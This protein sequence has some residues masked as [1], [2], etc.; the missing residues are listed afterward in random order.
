MPNTPSI[1]GLHLTYRLWIAEL[2]HDINLLRIFDDYLLEAKNKSV[3]ARI[4]EKIDAFKKSFSELR[5]E[6]D[7]LR[8]SM[9]LIKMKLASEAR[10]Q[11]LLPNPAQDPEEHNVIKKKYD[12]FLL[13]FEKLNNAVRE[14]IDESLQ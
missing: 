4:S 14:F 10:Q 7:E 1:M 5:T 8:H 9:H 13:S 12:A 11:D 3:E 6:I 2:N